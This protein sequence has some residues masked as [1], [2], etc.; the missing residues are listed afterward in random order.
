M[1]RYCLV[2]YLILGLL[3]ISINVRASAVITP[4]SIVV[5]Y[6]PSINKIYSFGLT[7]KGDSTLD[8]DIYVDGDLMDYINVNMQN[9]TLQPKE[10]VAVVYEL[11]LP[12]S[13][14]KPGSHLNFIKA[15]ERLQESVSGRGVQAVP[16]VAFTIEVLVPYPGDYLEA[17]INTPDS[18]QGGKDIDVHLQLSNM[19]TN[20]L[21]NIK[22]KVEFL[23]LENNKSMG[24]LKLDSVDIKS[25][26]TRNLIGYSS[27]KNWNLG[28]YSAVAT[29]NYG[30]NEIKLSKPF[31]VGD[32]EME[33]VGLNT[34]RYEQDSLNRIGVIVGSKWNQIINNIYVTVS[35]TDQNGRQIEARSQSLDIGPL[36][37]TEVPV[38]IDTSGFQAGFYKMNTKLFYFDKNKEKIFDIEIYKTWYKSLIRIE[39]ILIIIILILLVIFV[40]NYIKSHRIPKKKKK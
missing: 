34:T 35:L 2:A 10:G 27:T 6:E 24:V 5:F 9:I 33:I 4:P 11:N 28:A 21:N 36:G 30:A 14:L 15:K 12:E 7:N 22:S 8:F 18:V 20:D 23:S 31:N 32:I 3:I 16:E 39:S 13:G 25:K 19:G 40:F 26:E 29:I 1:K 38:F 37:V 17:A